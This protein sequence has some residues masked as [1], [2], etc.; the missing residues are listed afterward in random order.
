MHSWFVFLV[1]IFLLLGSGLSL[2]S[3]MKEDKGAAAYIAS[4]IQLAIAIGLIMHG[5]GVR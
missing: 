3:D 1:G 4:L 5:A 2:G